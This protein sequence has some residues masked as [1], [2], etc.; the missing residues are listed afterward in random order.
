MAVRWRLHAFELLDRLRA[1]IERLQRRLLEAE[2][3]AGQVV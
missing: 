3:R 1:F 2:R